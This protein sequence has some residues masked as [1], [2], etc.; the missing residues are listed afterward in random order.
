[1][2]FHPPCLHQICSPPWWSLLSLSWQ[3]SSVCYPPTPSGWPS[4]LTSSCLL[5]SSLLP[6][7]STP[8]LLP[9]P[10]LPIPNSRLVQYSIY[11]AS[12]SKLSDTPV[13]NHTVVLIGTIT[14]CGSLLGS[15]IYSLVGAHS[16]A[17]LK[18]LTP[19]SIPKSQP[20]PIPHMWL[21]KTRPS[22]LTVL[23]SLD[24]QTYWH[25]HSSSICQ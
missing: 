7:L 5:I 25:V 24:F 4:L 17:I 20:M 19:V 22:S 3:C 14:I 12:T 6:M 2:P 1:M 8:C 18:H 10:I 16:V 11:S 13:E 15:P 9:W 23:T 21:K